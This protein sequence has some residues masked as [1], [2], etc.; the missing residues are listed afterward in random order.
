MPFGV[1]RPF[2]FFGQHS[3]RQ[4]DFGEIKIIKVFHLDFLMEEEDYL[5]HLL[6]FLAL[7]FLAIFF[8]MDLQ[9]LLMKIRK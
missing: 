5:P 9:L 7:L 2:F 4:L 3:S 8:L 6:H 1:F